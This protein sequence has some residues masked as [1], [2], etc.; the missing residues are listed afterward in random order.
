MYTHYI[1]HINSWPVECILKFLQNRFYNDLGRFPWKGKE[2][3]FAFQYKY[4]FLLYLGWIDT[5]GKNGED[6]KE[7][8]Q[9]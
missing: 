1:G 2:Y 8:V 3:F 9:K 6:H 7:Y 4:I 5:E